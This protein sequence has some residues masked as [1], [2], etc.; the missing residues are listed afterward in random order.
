MF[1]AL[2]L[3]ATNLQVISAESLSADPRNVRAIYDGYQTK[4]GAILVDSQPIAESTPS[5]DAFNYT[6]EYDSDI[7][8]AVTGFYSYYQGAT[9]LESSANDYLNGKNSA[10]FFERLN[11]L[12]SGNPLTGASIELTIDPKLQKVAHDAMGNKTGAVIAIEPATGNILAMVSTPGF[13]ADKLS[14]HNGT[15]AQTNY[16]ALLEAPGDPLINKA[17]GGSLYTPGSVFKLVVAAAALESGDYTPESE[18]PNP[19]TYTLPNTTTKISNAGR[20]NCGGEETVSLLDA[21]KLSCNI[22]FAAL[23]VELGQD[24]I[25]KMANAFGFGTS[26]RIPT[27]ATAS[28]YP[29]NMDDAQTA[30]TAFGQF[31]VRVTPLQMALITAAIANGG[32]QMNPHLIENVQS[33]NLALLNQTR[34]SEFGS[35]ISKETA[36]GLKRMMIAAVASGVSGNAAVSGA[37]VAG[38]TGTAQNGTKDPYTL[39]FAGFAPA[40]NPQ[41][42]VVVMIA[43]GGG[44]GQNGSG[45]ILAAPIA[46]K[47]LQAVI[48]R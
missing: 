39:W 23:G 17:I 37:V 33:S 28:T 30:L 27:V 16:N 20:S 38:K 13:N 10:Q 40:D 24:R 35:P 26:F 46:K 7:Y 8:S 12:F 47:V 22:P 29:E 18:L 14:V 19:R 3:S 42:A 41:V 9:G 1:L 32:K 44:M 36:D 25:R 15:K 2:F 45:N 5:S 11:S 6:R 31:D 21:M 4:R 43:D 48:S 34:P